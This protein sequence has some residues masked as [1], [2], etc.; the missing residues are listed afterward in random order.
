MDHGR[1][2][3][4]ALRTLQMYLHAVRADSTGRH[5]DGSLLII[6]NGD[7]R[8]TEVRI[9]G[10]PW[11]RAYMQLW[12]SNDSRPPGGSPRTAIRP[13]SWVGIGANSVQL[14]DARSS[15]DRLL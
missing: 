4:P 9:P 14:Y 10:L 5:I 15:D 12:D 7:T 2:H 6:I 1:W 3:D 8:P 13:Q 11:A